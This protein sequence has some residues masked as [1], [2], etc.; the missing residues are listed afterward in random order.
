MSNAFVGAVTEQTGIPPVLLGVGIVWLLLAVLVAKV[1]GAFGRG[2]IVGPLRIGKG[3]SGWTLLTVF[4]FAAGAAWFFGVAVAMVCRKRKVDENMTLLVGGMAVEALAFLLLLILS[5]SIRPE[6]IERIGVKLRRFPHGM[7]LGLAAAFVLYPLVLG[8]SEITSAALSWAGVPDPKPNAVLE[9]VT[10]SQSRF[11]TIFGVAMAVIVAPLFEE[12]AFRG[13]LQ[14]ALSNLF[15]W[16]LRQKEDAPQM[17]SPSS[18]GN[19][20]LSYATPP[21]HPEYPVPAKARWAAVVI[22]AGCFAY[23]HGEWAFMPPLFVLA[24]GL[25]YLYERTGNLWGCIVAH[26]AF[27]GLQIFLALSVGAK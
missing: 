1:C 6:G 14:T 16:T 3:E 10:D 7:V 2:S 20:I 8:I 5:A 12:L 18:D 22:T 26:S 25:G 15:A 21:L 17:L 9:L 23:V 24:I 27:N 11:V 19:Q 4:F 13:F